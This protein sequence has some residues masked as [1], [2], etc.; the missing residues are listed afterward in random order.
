MGIVRTKFYLTFPVKIK[1]GTRLLR[2]SG[3]DV[4][5]DLR[6]GSKKSNQAD[7]ESG[8]AS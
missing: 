5:M 7:E 6:V 2:H 3:R 1:N 8:D 4:E